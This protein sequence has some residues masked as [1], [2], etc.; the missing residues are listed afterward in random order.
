MIKTHGLTHIALGY[1]GAPFP[2]RLLSGPGSQA[3]FTG[4]DHTS[5]AQPGTHSHES[6]KTFGFTRFRINLQTWPFGQLPAQTNSG[7]PPPLP[8]PGVTSTM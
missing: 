2:Y 1:G 7:V 6:S 5:A 8:G 3:G 4:C